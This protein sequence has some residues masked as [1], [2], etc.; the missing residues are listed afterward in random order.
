M[1]VRLIRG[2]VMAL[3]AFAAQSALADVLVGSWTSRDVRRYGDDGTFKGIFVAAGSGGLQTP[4]GLAYGPDGDLYVSSAQQKAVLR[5]DGKTG[6]LVK[7]FATT[8]IGR[9]GYC[10]WGPDGKLYVC[11]SGTHSVVRFDSQGGF[12]DTFVSGG[13]LNAPTSLLWHGGSLYVSSYGSGEV[14][15]CDAATGAK[16]SA[17]PVGTNPMYLRTS[18]EGHLQV[19]EYGLNRVAKYDFSTG[20]LVSSFT[21]G[22]MLGPVGQLA[23]PD[24]SVLVTSWNNGRVLRFSGDGSSFIGTFATLSRANDI[25]AMPVPAPGV[26]VSAMFAA[27]FAGVR[28]RR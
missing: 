22:G 25:I 14:L 4:D 13:G 6:A 28:R 17:I 18:P 19:V 8:N 26:T 10:A 9:A 23:M 5:F 15:K 16:S 12:V 24:G 20:A 3:G 7:P 1:C 2:M 21:G 11:D 27:A